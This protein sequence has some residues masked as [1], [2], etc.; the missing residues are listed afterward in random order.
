[1][2]LNIVVVVI[3]IKIPQVVTHVTELIHLPDMQGIA[4]LSEV[5]YVSFALKY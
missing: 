4:S 2:R 5:C 3:I 1:M